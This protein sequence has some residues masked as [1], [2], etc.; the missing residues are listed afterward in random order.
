MIFAHTVDHS[1]WY[2]ILVERC[3]TMGYYGIRWETGSEMT[4]PI[5]EL[6]LYELHHLER[7]LQTDGYQIV[8]QDDE[9]EDVVG[10]TFTVD[11]CVLVS[12]CM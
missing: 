9:R 11:T 5:D 6:C 4:H 7:H 8:V 12:V 10:E 2:A 3:D 1:L